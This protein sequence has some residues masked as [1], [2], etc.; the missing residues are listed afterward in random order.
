MLG[1]LAAGWGWQFANAFGISILAA[2]SSF[3]FSMLIGIGLTLFSRA[4]I[5]GSRAIVNSYTY[6]FRSLPD[7][8]LLLLIFYT[9]DGVFQAALSA[10]SGGASIRLSPLVPAIMSTSIVLGAYA[11]ELF[12]AGWADIPAGQHE[13]GQALGLTRLQSLLLVILPQVHL[14]EGDCAAEHHR[15][16]RH[17]AGRVDRRPFHGG[18][19]R[20][21]RHRHHHLRGVCRRLCARLQAP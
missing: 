7:I 12:K 15:Y 8:L 14:D 10:F 20:L 18:A 13:A 1:Y 19:L 3:F 5:P 17:R 16:F 9:L 11:T 6:V 2:I 4:P 21:L